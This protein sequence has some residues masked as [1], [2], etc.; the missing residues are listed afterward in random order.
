MPLQPDDWQELDSA[1]Q[2]C[3]QAIRT[4]TRTQLAVMREKINADYGE[5]R[6]QWKFT[7]RHYGAILGE[8]DRLETE[9]SHDAAD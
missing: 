2:A 9:A 6:D 7:Q 4:M 3:C 8:I 5:L 1:T